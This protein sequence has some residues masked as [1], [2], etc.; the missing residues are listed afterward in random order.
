[1]KKMF[2]KISQNSQENSCVRNYATLLNIAK[3]SRTA[4]LQNIP[5]RLFLS[6]TI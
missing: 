6:M 2:L 4:F 1:M 5:E 3:F